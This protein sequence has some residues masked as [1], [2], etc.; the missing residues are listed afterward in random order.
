M[1]FLREA[2]FG[3]VVAVNG[4]A[5]EDIPEISLQLFVAIFWNG[6]AVART[7]RSVCGHGLVVD[8]AEQRGLL[9]YGRV[10]EAFAEQLRALLVD[11]GQA[12]EKRLALFVVGPIG[13]DDIDEFVDLARPWRPAYPSPE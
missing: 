12:V 6:V 5:L 1:L 9:V 8:S 11:A 2:D 13:Q 10:I 4:H 3:S 7:R